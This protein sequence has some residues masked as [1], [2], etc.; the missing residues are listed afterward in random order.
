M[1]ETMKICK[2][3]NFGSILAVAYIVFIFYSK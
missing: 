2:M 1:N 3:Y